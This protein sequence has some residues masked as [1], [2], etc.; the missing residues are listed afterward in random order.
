MSK[1]ELERCF[2]TLD[3]IDPRDR[4]AVTDDQRALAMHELELINQQL[5]D[6]EKVE[7]LK[8]GEVGVG[9]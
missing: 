5:D 2:E 3:K 7:I 6:R 1:P 4:P 9:E 8:F